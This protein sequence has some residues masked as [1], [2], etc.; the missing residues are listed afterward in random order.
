MQPFGRAED[1]EHHRKT[2]DFDEVGGD[3]QADGTGRIVAA[4][5]VAD[6][7]ADREEGHDQE[8]A[9]GARKQSPGAV[10]DGG[11]NAREDKSG[12]P[13]AAAQISS[14]ATVT[15]G[16]GDTNGSVAGR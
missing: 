12:Q 15:C 5:E 14:R 7:E 2:N 4:D 16:A 9:E 8:T 11:R 10:E 1:E 3:K 6:Q 13:G